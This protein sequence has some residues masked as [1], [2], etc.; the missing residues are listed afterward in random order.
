M[1]GG[2]VLE[3]VI[4]MMAI[5]NGAQVLEKLFILTCEVNGIDYE[6]SLNHEN[7][8]EFSNLSWESE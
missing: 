8:I 6:S 3:K 5:G 4:P 7:F 2:S 1:D